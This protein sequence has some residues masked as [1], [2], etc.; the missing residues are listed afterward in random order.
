MLGEIFLL[1]QYTH[2]IILFVCIECTQA[3]TV[4][5]IEKQSEHA[6]EIMYAPL[7]RLS[8]ACDKVEQ[9]KAP[10]AKSDSLIPP[11][12]HPSPASTR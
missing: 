9:V 10:D 2:S 12:P 6:C 11:L 3:V 4:L 8:Q 1:T 5:E 7:S